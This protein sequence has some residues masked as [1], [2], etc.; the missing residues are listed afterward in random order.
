MNSIKYNV[1]EAVSYDV[2]E[3]LK[4]VLENSEEDGLVDVD[5]A[6]HACAVIKA[7]QQEIIRLSKQNG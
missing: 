3:F 6:L 1:E 7:L 5:Y 4:D 2:D